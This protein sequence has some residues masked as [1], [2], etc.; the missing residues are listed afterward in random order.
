MHEDYIKKIS[1][2]SIDHYLSTLA[3]L[4]GY[5]RGAEVEG[6]DFY[7]DLIRAQISNDEIYIIYFALIGNDEY[8]ELKRLCTEA[9]IFKKLT[10]DDFHY[11]ECHM[12]FYDQKAFGLSEE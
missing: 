10:V 12:R 11:G 5:V 7:N 1:S 9:S 4:L 2:S 3:S 6:K 8:T